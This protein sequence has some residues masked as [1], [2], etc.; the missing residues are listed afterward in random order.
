MS[1]NA[2]RG[3]WPKWATDQ[4]PQRHGRTAGSHCQ[5]QKMIV[6]AGRT[7]RLD[8][9]ANTTITT[10]VGSIEQAHRCLA[11]LHEDSRRLSRSPALARS[12]R[13]RGR[14]DRDRSSS[15]QDAISL[16]GSDWYRAASTGGR[17]G[18]LRSRDRDRAAP[19]AVPWPLSDTHASTAR[20]LADAKNSVPTDKGGGG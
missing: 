1:S 18:A 2:L 20:G 17:A 9:L 16:H 19:V 7:V 11:L 15:A 3:T 6:S 12:W 4:G 14:R 8:V 13:R 5:Q 10:E